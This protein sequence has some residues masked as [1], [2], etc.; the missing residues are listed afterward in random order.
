MSQVI[1]T[2]I[3]DEAPDPRSPFL[4]RQ[5]RL[6][7]YD[8]YGDVLGQARWVELLWLLFV[9]EP[10][11]PDQAELLERL[12]VALANPGPRDPAVHAAMCGGIGGSRPAAQLMAAL[13]VASGDH[14]GAGEL[15]R[16]MHAWQ[17]SEAN[18]SIATRLTAHADPEGNWPGFSP[19]SRETPEAV[20]LCL[21]HL[22]A[23]PLARCLTELRE[24]EPAL[25]RGATHGLS[26]IGVAAAAFV[27]LGLSPDQGE[28][29]F[30][31]LRLPGALAHGMEQS[32]HRHKQ[33]PFFTLDEIAMEPPPA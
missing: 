28:A 11:T 15:R 3:W 2:R 31:L 12:A 10:P 29:L 5:V 21:T 30:L 17:D 16:A 33:F 27:D 18:V 25:S 24:H 4:G 1:R 9:G 14:G 32:G 8:Y 22:L 7:G 13:A 23:S 26:L 19:L 6:F 20:F